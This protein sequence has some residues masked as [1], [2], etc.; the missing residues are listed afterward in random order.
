MD[1]QHSNDEPLSTGIMELDLACYVVFH[2]NQ[3]Y[4]KN[5]TNNTSLS[6]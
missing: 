6:C 2:L 1:H 4:K 3:L 5:R